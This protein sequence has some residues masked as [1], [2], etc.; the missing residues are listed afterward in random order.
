[1]VPD[2]TNQ[3]ETEELAFSRKNISRC[4]LSQRDGWFQGKAPLSQAPML[5]RLLPCNVNH[6]LLRV[7]S[8]SS[9][10][11]FLGL[12]S[13][14]NDRC[15]SRTNEQELPCYSVCS[16]LQAPLRAVKHP[17]ERHD[18][19]APY[20]NKPK[21]GK[22]DASP[23]STKMSQ[24]RCPDDVKVRLLL[25]TGCVPCQRTEELTVPSRGSASEAPWG[26]N[27]HAPHAPHGR[28]VRK[29]AVEV[30]Q[31]PYPYTAA[32]SRES[33]VHQ[34]GQTRP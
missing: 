34:T 14:Y 18:L 27:L 5:P 3:T 25:P 7:G 26:G 10:P 16:G 30:W 11:T 15:T 19:R 33:G 9:N 4:F 1:M 23:P 21:A 8:P 29:M 24:I 6:N 2:K 22:G 31:A 28:T 17:S 20:G 12:R 32:Q 13:T